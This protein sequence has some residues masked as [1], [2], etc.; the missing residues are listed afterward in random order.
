MCI[1]VTVEFNLG[2]RFSI[3]THTYSFI[4]LIYVYHICTYVLYSCGNLSLRENNFTVFVVLWN[5]R[6]FNI[7][8][9]III[10]SVEHGT[11]NVKIF[12]HCIILRLCDCETFLPRNF[13]YICCLRM[14]L[15][16]YKY[17]LHTCIVCPS[18]VPYYF[19]LWP[20]FL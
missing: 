13:S 4:T 12:T 8:Y 11:A 9:S 16:I 6:S 14:C 19:K 3:L 15:S 2:N 10:A 18:Y 20:G 5:H 7:I 17:M 1:Q